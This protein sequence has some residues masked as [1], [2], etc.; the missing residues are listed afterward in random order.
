MLDLD[1]FKKYNDTFGHPAGDQLLADIASIITAQMRE[2]DLVVRYGGEEFL[3]IL[4][5]TDSETALQIAER[6][7]TTVMRNE[8]FHDG[9]KDPGQITV[10][11]GLVTYDR[12]MEIDNEDRII[13]MADEALYHA[14]N[15]GRN[16]VEVY[17]GSGEQFT[18]A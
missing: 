1:Y 15:A 16:R 12:T 6:I 8:I 14:K 13:V 7:R 17:K 10:S 9:H 18:Q 3:I 5:E 11:L 2:S 4:Q